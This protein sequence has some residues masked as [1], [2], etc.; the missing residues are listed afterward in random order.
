MKTKLFKFLT[1]SF[2]IMFQWSFAQKSV[3]GT[4]SDDAGVPIPGATVLVVDTN[5]GVTT[6]FDG[7]YTIMASEGDVLSVSYVGYNTQNVTVGASAP[8]NVTLSSDSL[9]EV[10]V[11]A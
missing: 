6:D 10:V 9:E 1:L 7:V 8:L 2:L 4:V 11:T 5:N 3:S